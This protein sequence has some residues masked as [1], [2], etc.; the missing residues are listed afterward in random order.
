MKLDVWVFLQ[1]N[2]GDCVLYS[3]PVLLMYLVHQEIVVVVIIW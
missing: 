3:S 2:G 1:D